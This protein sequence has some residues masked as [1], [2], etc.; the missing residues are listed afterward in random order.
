MSELKRNST[1]KAFPHEWEF[2]R[3]META[4]RMLEARGHGCVPPIQNPDVLYPFDILHLVD[5][6]IEKHCP[7]NEIIS[8]YGTLHVSMRNIWYDHYTVIEKTSRQLKLPKAPP[9][10][11]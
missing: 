8:L 1:P 2:K 6:M 10:A 5:D 4:E 9:E 11:T 7:G 3:C